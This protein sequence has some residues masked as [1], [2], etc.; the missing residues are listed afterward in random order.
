MVLK[1]LAKTSYIEYEIKILN[2]QVLNDLLYF[3]ED[4][5]SMMSCNWHIWDNWNEIKHTH[6]NSK[7]GYKTCTR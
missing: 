5:V 6:N 2:A 1:L 3:K 7:F 4:G